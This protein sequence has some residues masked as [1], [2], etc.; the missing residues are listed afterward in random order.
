M[1]L[2]FTPNDDL[3]GP[4][5]QPCTMVVRT[6]HWTVPHYSVWGLP[7][8]LF[9]STRA[10]QFLH[11]KPN[12]SFLRTMLCYLLSPLVSQPFLT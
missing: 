1:V 3:K 6:L 5:G 8:F 4:E 10:S 7:F 12:Q 2:T 9:Y 11:E